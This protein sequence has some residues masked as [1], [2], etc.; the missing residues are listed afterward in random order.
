MAKDNGMVSGSL[1]L[2]YMGVYP[3]WNNDLGISMPST[4]HCVL[5]PSRQ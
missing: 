4:H 1:D 5:T 3:I 2:S